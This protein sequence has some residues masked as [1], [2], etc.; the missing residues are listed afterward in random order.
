MAIASGSD[1]IQKPDEGGDAGN[2]RQI[3]QVSG[4]AVR[5][6]KRAETERQRHR[7]GKTNEKC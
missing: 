7:A 2:P 5:R 3:P 6:P 1:A 4:D